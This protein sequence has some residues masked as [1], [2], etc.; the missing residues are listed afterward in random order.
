M[1]FVARHRDF[2]RRALEPFFAPLPGREVRRDVHGFVKGLNFSPV[3]HGAQ[4]LPDS[5]QRVLYTVG[6][7]APSFLTASHL[8][9]FKYD[10][11]DKVMGPIFN[12]QGTVTDGR[13]YHPEE[14]SHQ[15]HPER[16]LTWMAHDGAIYPSFI[17]RETLPKKLAEE[18]RREIVEFYS[19]H[20]L[21]HELTHTVLKPHRPLNNAL[22][23][24]TMDG[25]SIAYDQWR[26]EF[27]RSFH[28][29]KAIGKWPSRYARSFVLPTRLESSSDE[30]LLALEE[31]SA[32]M[33]SRW[34]LGT[35]PSPAWDHG[36]QL[37]HVDFET[38]H[39]ELHRLIEQLC[40]SSFIPPARKEPEFD[41]P[42]AALIGD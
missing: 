3:P 7:R 32:E 18:T 35:S 31:L 16:V 8:R 12:D 27:V 26:E 2:Y 20:V 10:Y 39:P 25:R 29:D 28:R 38:A 21:L 15:D 33:T 36:D 6:Q 37:V 42:F 22:L 23:L 13:A 17:P 14:W 40:T 11:A 19:T 30:E 5:I 34:F 4:F 24:W 9:G 41:G 1:R